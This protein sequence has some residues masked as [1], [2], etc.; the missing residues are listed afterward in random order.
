M[1]E[2]AI[3]LGMTALHSTAIDVTVQSRGEQPK[4]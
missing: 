1:T 3:V 2:T 4:V